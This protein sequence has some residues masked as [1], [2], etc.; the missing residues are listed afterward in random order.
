MGF[1]V[2]FEIVPS[3]FQP[4]LVLLQKTIELVARFKAQ[5]PAELGGGEL[6]HGKLQGRLLQERRGRGPGRKQPKQQKARLADRE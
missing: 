4:G 3:V 2:L 5:D 6:V 1:P